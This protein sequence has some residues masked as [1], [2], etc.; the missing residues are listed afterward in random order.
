[1]TEVISALSLDAVTDKSLGE[2][3]FR[4]QWFKTQQKTKN[5]KTWKENSGIIKV[6]IMVECVAVDQSSGSS[7]GSRRK[8]P[9]G[10]YDRRP[11]WPARSVRGAGRLSFPRRAP[12]VPTTAR[13]SPCAV[14]TPVRQA[15]RPPQTL[16][17][18]PALASTEPRRRCRQ[19]LW[20][21]GDLSGSLFL[22]ELAASL[23][24]DL[25]LQRE[26]RFV[27]D[28]EPIADL[29]T[30][31]HRLPGVLWNKKLSSLGP[32]VLS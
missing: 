30:G 8:G 29:V 7:R 6:L 1:M 11:G 18:A 19:L 10:Q 26:T 17:A 25:T 4:C 21:L 14:W 3:I 12:L 27:F 13:R 20:D 16:L 32:E 22:A 23:L 5:K 24:L 15:P 2:R 9:K 28:P 31:T